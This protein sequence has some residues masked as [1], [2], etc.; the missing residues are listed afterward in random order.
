MNLRLIGILSLIL[1]LTACEAI[2][3]QTTAKRQSIPS[4]TAL[5][6]NAEKLF[7]ETFHRGDYQKIPEVNQQLMAAYLENPRDPQLAAH[8]G[9][10]HIWAI[11]ER[12]R[13]KKLPPTIPNEIVL[14]KFY[15][16]NAVELNPSDARYLGFYGVSQLA[17][18]KIFYDQREQVRGYFTLRKAIHQW[19]EFNYFTAGYPMTVLSPD[20]KYFREA[21][22]W[23]WATMNLCAGERI[24]H[25]N[26][27]FQPYMKLETQQGSKRVCWNSWIAPYNFEGFF[28][29]MGDM[30]VKSGDWQTAIKIYE[31]AKLA[32][33][34][35]LWP[36]K[37]NL[38]ERIQHAQ[39]N[40]INF[41]K[42]S[43]N[44]NQAILFN[45]GYGCMACHEEA[46][47]KKS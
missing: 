22:Q 20:T 9:F 39:E 32:Q 30:L 26:P 35:N 13:M 43:K 40:T 45:S 23:Q 31:N 28:M 33:N 41:Q 25:A 24:N 1:I 34:Y 46:V 7:W 38:E 14:A 2:A 44:P 15:F 36:Y 37:K 10:L 3:V 27:S 5:A 18:G 29:N 4:N 6:N 42:E 21:L 8:L 16:G 12:Q 19:P 17:E 11:T 47:K